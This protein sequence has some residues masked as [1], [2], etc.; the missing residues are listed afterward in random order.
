MIEEGYHKK[1]L[2]TNEAR[3]LRSIRESLEKA[4]EKTRS[5]VEKS[6]AYYV[7]RVKDFS[8]KNYGL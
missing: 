6:L 4:P 8:K 1:E 5:F 2:A 7:G 3:A